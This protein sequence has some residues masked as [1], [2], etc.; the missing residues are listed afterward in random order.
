MRSDTSR[1]AAA[2]AP[3]LVLLDGMRGIAAICVV[4]F[5]ANLTAFGRLFAQAG[6][7]VDLFFLLSGFVLTLA[8]EDRLGEGLG[9]EAFLRLRLKRFVPMT[10]LGAVLGGIAYWGTTT[11]LSLVV[12]VV[13]AAVM[14]PALRSSSLYPVNPPQWSLLLE[15]GANFAHGL[16]LARLST[17]RLAMVTALFGVALVVTFG[18]EVPKPKGQELSGISL[19]MLTR[20]GWCYCGGILFARAWRE[21][22]RSHLRLDWRLALALPFVATL[23]WP[24][25]PLQGWAGSAVLILVVY[26]PLFWLAASTEA[27]ARA[28]PLLSA[29]GALS[30]PLYALHFGVLVLYERAMG[31]EGHLFAVPTALALAAAVAW[32]QPKL[33]RA[34]RRR[35]MM[36]ATTA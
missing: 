33:T 16:V 35:R 21:G 11:P 15:I 10:A 5:H 30:F 8:F 13:C 2:A 7:C 28:A 26:P 23:A 9:A 24:Y 6:S 20:L 4:L 27:P 1:P 3:R 25:Q 12:S 34:L 17:R 19:T 32:A 31:M 14:V 22:R 36:V 18:T 29:L